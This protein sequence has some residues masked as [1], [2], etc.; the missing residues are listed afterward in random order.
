MGE[1]DTR[2]TQDFWNARYDTPDYI[3]GTAPS[4]FLR[5]YAGLIP[6][7]SNIFLPADGEGR[8]GVYLAQLGHQVAAVDYAENGVEKARRLA[9]EAGVTLD[10]R[11]ANLKGYDWPE[12]AYDAI[13]AIFIQFAPPDFRAE[14]LAG[15]KRAVKPGGLI[16][17]H[18]YTPKQLEYGTGG[19]SEVDKLYT[20]DMLRDAFADMDVLTLKA[21]EA[22]LDEGPAHRGRS[23]LIDLIA[24]RP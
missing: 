23:A 22:E 14:I 6:P 2:I 12:A 16:L 5:D 19:P 20:E 24:R 3:F 1:S 17:L 13:A 10:M 9:A 18:G 15:M 8:N 11:Q 7:R 4:A 21:Y